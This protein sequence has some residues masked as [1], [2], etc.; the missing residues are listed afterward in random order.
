[1]NY[2]NQKVLDVTSSKDE[3]GAPVG[4]AAAKYVKN[5]NSTSTE[6]DEASG[7]GRCYRS[8]KNG[9]PIKDCRCHASC[10]AC[11]YSANPI[12]EIDCIRCSDPKQKVTAMFNYGVGRC[13]NKDKKKEE[14][15][16][17]KATINAANQRWRVVYLDK[18]TKVA[19]EGLNA[20]FG[21]FV[22]RPFYLRSR[23][24]MQRVAECHGAS[25]VYLKRW[26]KNVNA[27]QWFFDPVAKVIRSN[28]WKNYIM[29]I[30]SNG[31]ANDLRMTSSVTSR[32]W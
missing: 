20:D 31:N 13:V 28:H 30:P 21:F 12:R 2:K 17:Y 26:R 10:G 19:T 14:Q 1:V 4:V 8:K 25:N 7:P 3:E 16:A 29:N 27:Q 9:T 18:A 15:P 23:L 22:N 32:W 11:G 5:T 24:P 6:D